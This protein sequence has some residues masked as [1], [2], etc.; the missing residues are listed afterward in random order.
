MSSIIVSGEQS[1]SDITIGATGVNEIIQN[2][3]MILSTIKGSVYLDR[4]F[5]LNPDFIDMPQMQ[6]AFKYREEIINQIELNE[7]RVNVIEI[8]FTTDK[9]DAMN[10]QLLPVVK[11]EIKSGV[12]L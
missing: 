12:L 6:A 8:N 11:I 9:N 3:R 7:P 2:V 4:D 1:V 10:G 5:G